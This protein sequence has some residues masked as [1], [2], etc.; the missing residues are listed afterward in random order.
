MAIYLQYEGIEGDA[1]QKNH[2]KWFDIQSLQWGVG[3]GIHTPVGSA[4][5]REASEPSVSEVTVTMNMD[6][7]STKMFE[8]ACV[9]KKGKKVV[10]D[11]ITTG[12]E[13]QLYLQYT[14]DKVLVSGYSISS[15]GDR[16]SV[17]L[18]FNFTKIELKYTTYDEGNE[19]PTNILAG[20]NIGDGKKV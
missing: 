2:K 5:N 13:G 20:Y 10:V 19:A 16:P 4:Q 6:G 11:F 1:T 9:G 15:G 8:E 14:L 17:S 18:S 3:R 12:D 7:S